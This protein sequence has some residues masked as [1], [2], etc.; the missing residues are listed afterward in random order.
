[1]VVVFSIG[2]TL[3]LSLWTSTTSHQ[4]PE[5]VLQMECRDRYFMI[6]V[7][8]SFTGEDP[9]F[10]VV[11]EM[12]AYP[13][14]ESYGAQ[15]G[16]TVRILLSQG[17]VELRASFFS[18]H[19]SSQDDLLFTFSFNLIVSRDG[20][21][22][23][24]PLYKTC[25][26]T[27][28]WAPREV[29]CEANYMEVSVKSDE[30]CPT[31]TKEDDWNASTQ[32]VYTYATSE[33]QV[34]LKRP[35]QLMIPINISEAS[36]RGYEFHLTEGRLA[37]RTPYGQ[38]DS[39]V[40]PV[41]GVPV[42]VVHA[43]LFSRQG[44]IIIKVDLLA[45]CSMHEGSHENGYLQWKMPEFLDSTNKV[46]KTQVAVGIN[47]KLQQT[48][49][50][51]LGDTS[52]SSTE[53]SGYVV[54]LQNSIFQIRIPYNAEGRQR[55]SLVSDGLK[56]FYIF[57][58]YLEQIL[59]DED[60]VS[61]RVRIFRT[62]VTPLLPRPLL[63]VNET[64]FEE[65]TF[66]VYLGDIPEDVALVAVS[67]NGRE[68][69]LQE[70]M[71]DF[72]VTAVAHTNNT[73]GYT[74]KVPFDHPVVIQQFSKH[75]NAMKYTVT[76]Q[77]TLHVLPEKEPIYHQTAIVA[78]MDASPPEVDAFC[79]DSGIR[80]TL[81]HRPFDHLWQI[82][83]GSDL[84]SSELATRH[85]YIVTNDSQR[86]QLDVPLFTTGYKYNNVTLKGFSGT[87][88][89]LLRDP[90]ASEVHRSITKTCP[91]SLSQYISCS[92][93][94][95]M[96][97]MVDLSPNI[98]NGVIPA[99]THLL[100][101]N[102]RPKDSDRTTVLFSFPLNSCGTTVK[103]GKEAVTYQN[104]IFLPS[105]SHK[106]G[107]SLEGSHDLQSVTIQCTY[108]LDGLHRFF[109]TYMFDSDTTGVG[110]IVYAKQPS[111]E[112]QTSTTQP[113]TAKRKW[114]IFLQP[115]YRFPS[116]YVKMPNFP[117]VSQRRGL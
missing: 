15:H 91:F 12:G 68:F 64:L 62:L 39:F 35:G 46:D 58:L 52:N 20:E 38:P 25:S 92:T 98:Q 75:D 113:T 63:C 36:R 70:I 32:M 59:L 3:L 19:T 93:N 95:T 83:I 47:G 9:Q 41:N 5:G 103:V 111:H 94:G 69:S 106:G 56:E 79:S 85:G 100:D 78:L 80:F 29:T 67:L 74:L 77:F 55:K 17:L 28:T 31:K 88:E 102:C 8:L 89:V 11:D 114:S 90:E 57:N 51:G 18:H 6:A 24:F 99:R 26:P 23:K 40:A 84:L 43:I 44:W 4:I 97:V 76:I 21:N 96:T 82:T 108:P 37:F 110:R 112:L 13:I 34:A 61:V 7:N 54:Q 50:S 49:F 73:H 53:Q 27:L 33:W 42:E 116:G 72:T 60:Q 65:R 45:A 115:S 2:L 104:E 22:V 30:A 66:L 10:E 87:F 16:Y 105:E 1:M 71:I 48:H 117:T 109:W 86:L 107:N 101:R 14:T 81:E